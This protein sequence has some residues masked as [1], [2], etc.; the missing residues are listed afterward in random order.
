M[1]PRT[2]PVRFSHGLRGRG[3]ARKAPTLHRTAGSRS[4]RTSTV[5]VGG[6]LR[7]LLAGRARSVAAINDLSLFLDGLE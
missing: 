3:K 4:A 6:E 5:G 1:N 7:Q 2:S